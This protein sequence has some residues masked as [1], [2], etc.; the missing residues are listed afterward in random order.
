MQL[1]IINFPLFK[2]HNM[3]LFTESETL[4]RRHG[5]EVSGHGATIDTTTNT[6]AHRTKLNFN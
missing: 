4:E 6:L 5:L 1:C 3:W 2:L